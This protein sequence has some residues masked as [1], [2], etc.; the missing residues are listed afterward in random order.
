MREEQK[1]ISALFAD[2]VGSTKLAERLDA[3][4]LKLVVGEA[5]ARMVAEIESLGGYVEDLGPQTRP[6]VRA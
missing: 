6:F 5:V 2:L 3:E 4:D 1:I